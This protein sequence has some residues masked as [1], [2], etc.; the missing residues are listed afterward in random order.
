MKTMFQTLDCTIRDGGYIN[1]WDFPLRMVR[2]I[3]WRLS[4]AGVDYVEVGFRDHADDNTPLWRRSPENELQLVKKDIHGAKLSV[5]VDYGKTTTDDFLPAEDSA[6]DM[7]RVAVH[8]DKV[9]Q[10]LDFCEALQEKGYI[11]S[12]QLMGYPQY[13]DHERQD[14]LRRLESSSLGYVYV[15]DS[16][17]S[18]LPDEVHSILQPLVALNRFNVGFHAHNN[19]QLA[20][21][22]S[23]EA[24]KAGA[25]IVDST[26]YGMGRGAGNLAT[27]TLLSYLQQQNTDKYNVIHALFCVDMYMLGLKKR[28]DWGYQLPFMLSAVCQCHPSFAREVVEAREYTVDEL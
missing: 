12:I 13:E 6:I 9:P 27:E 10:A 26:L 16:Y 7:I 23:L 24:M 17:G 28:Y 14:V 11:L 5:M 2:D 3:Y 1:N 21:A 15:A 22:N 18:L 8:K 25:R 4:R 20:F 19:L